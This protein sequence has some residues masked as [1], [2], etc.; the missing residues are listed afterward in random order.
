MAVPDVKLCS[1]MVH[2]LD[3]TIRHAGH[4]D[5]LRE[6]LDG[7]TGVAAGQHALAD[8]LAR[9]AHCVLLPEGRRSCRCDESGLTSPL[10]S[11]FLD[12]LFGTR[13]SAGRAVRLSLFR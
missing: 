2:V 8:P 12:E 4:A 7:R 5:I 6:N 3:D 10:A 1:V 13:S 9:D 11:T